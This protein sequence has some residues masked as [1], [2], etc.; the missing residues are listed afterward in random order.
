MLMVMLLHSLNLTNQVSL[1]TADCPG[2][3]QLMDAR[4]VYLSSYLGF[5]GEPTISNISYSPQNFS[6]GDDVFITAL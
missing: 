3:T 1:V 4:A 6:L 5:N 2:I